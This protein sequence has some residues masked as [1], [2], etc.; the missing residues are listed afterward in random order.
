MDLS[1]LVITQPSGSGLVI[2]LFND[3]STVPRERFV[4]FTKGKKFSQQLRKQIHILRGLRRFLSLK[5]VSGFG[6]YQV[7]NI[8]PYAR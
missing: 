5:T 3:D 6:V 7:R 8:D 4:P 1:N 2:G